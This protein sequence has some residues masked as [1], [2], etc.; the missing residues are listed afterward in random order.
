[1]IKSWL[2][3]KMVNR[4]KL[5]KYPLEELEKKHVDLSKPYPNDSS[6][7]YGG[8]LSGNAFICRLAFRG[9]N[10]TPEFWYDISLA[11][12]GK[13]G[14]PQSG[15]K[16]GAG[17]SQG[18]LSYSPAVIG[19]R[20][21]ITCNGDIIDELGKPHPHELH[22]TFAATQPLFDYT[23]SSDK[24][25]VAEAI[26]REPWSIKFFRDLQDLEQTHYEQFGE[27]TGDIVIDGE[28]VPLK[29][30]A[31]RDHS[32][33]S[34][35]WRTWDRHYW[36]SGRTPDGWGWTAVAIRYNFCGP[37]YAGFIVSPEGTSDA[38]TFST[39]LAEIKPGELWPKTSAITVKTR[40]GKTY[41][42]EYERRGVFPY[43][44]DG[45]YHMLEGIGSYR[46]NGQEAAG[47]LEFGFSQEK[48]GNTIS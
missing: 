35:D 10:R 11:G 15:A 17:F 28:T 48:Y 23:D 32:F 7:F 40:S 13:F 31:V 27:L 4:T 30:L 9:P 20:W 26:A 22:L 18:P 45:A 43:L 29:L 46:F 5:R 1:M 2:A 39:P 41:T 14:I 3:K 8:D 25:L 47:L 34:R 12:R 38:I 19:K 36:I 44:M 6:C 24:N 16:S 33:G 37:L 42:I 21:D